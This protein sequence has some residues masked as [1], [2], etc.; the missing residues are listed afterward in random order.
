MK[1]YFILLV[2]FF[3][4]VTFADIKMN[5]NSNTYWEIKSLNQAKYQTRKPQENLLRFSIS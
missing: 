1:K 2:L 5:P 4:G 3:I